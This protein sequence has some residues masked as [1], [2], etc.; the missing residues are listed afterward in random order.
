MTKMADLLCIL[1]CAVLTV[2]SFLPKNA[3]AQDFH[4]FSK[5]TVSMSANSFVVTQSVPNVFECA[6]LC[7]RSGCKTWHYQQTE[8]SCL[9]KVGSLILLH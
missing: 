6:R 1:T 7:A 4:E 9:T 3:N 2:M 8:R 5:I